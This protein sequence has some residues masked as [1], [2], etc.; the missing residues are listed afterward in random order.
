MGMAKRCHFL[1]WMSLETFYHHI[2]K[3]K[4]RVTMMQKFSIQKRSN[5]MRKVMCT[6]MP[7]ILGKLRE[8]TALSVSK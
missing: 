6:P 5:A 7:F 2:A 3:K 1:D 4:L 8:N